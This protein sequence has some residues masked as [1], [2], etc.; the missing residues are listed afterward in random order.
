MSMGASLDFCAPRKVSFQHYAAKGASHKLDET[1]LMTHKYTQ[2]FQ[3]ARA[4]Y[5]VRQV[6]R[7]RT[8][9]SNDFQISEALS[10]KA[11]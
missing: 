4:A 9:F 8:T 2:Q 10:H 6:L 7:R 11:K 5:S 3:A 1:L